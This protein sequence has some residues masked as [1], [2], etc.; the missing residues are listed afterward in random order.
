MTIR[1]LV[2]LAVCV[3]VFFL[4]PSTTTADVICTDGDIAS[5]NAERCASSYRAELLKCLRSGQSI[6][7]CP[8]SKSS[9]YCNALSDSCDIRTAL[10]EVA[11][12]INP[13]AVSSNDCV[14][15][16]TSQA[17]KLS[18][19]RLKRERR[20]QFSKVF[21]DLVAAVE[22]SSRACGSMPT[23]ASSC[24][25]MPTVEDGTACVLSAALG[26]SGVV[27]TF[28]P[29]VIDSIL[30]FA[31]S[32][33]Y[34]TGSDFFSCQ[35]VKRDADAFVISHL[36]RPDTPHPFDTALLIYSEKNNAAFVIES[37]PD[38]TTTIF[39]EVGGVRY[40]PAT[41]TQYF[42]GAGALIEG[43]KAAATALPKT[44]STTTASLHCN[45]AW[46][47][48]QCQVPLFDLMGCLG[49]SL[50]GDL[51]EFAN[52]VRTLDREQGLWLLIK[53]LGISRANK[54][55]VK[56]GTVVSCLDL[57]NSSTKDCSAYAF[58][59]GTSCT[60]P[61][62]VAD[63]ACPPGGHCAACVTGYSCRDGDC[64]ITAYSPAGTLCRERGCAGG[65]GV[66][67]GEC[68]NSGDPLAHD[69]LAP[70]CIPKG[71]P[72]LLP[73]VC[74]EESGEAICAACGNDRLDFGEVCDGDH[75]SPLRTC[76][77][78]GYVSGFLS[79]SPSCGLE[80]D[81]CLP[82]IA[83]EFH[84]FTCG[85]GSTVCTMHDGERVAVSALATDVNGDIVEVICDSYSPEGVPVADCGDGT[86]APTPMYSV[87]AFFNPLE[88]GDRTTDFSI[89]VSIRVIDQAGLIGH[90]P[91]TITLLAR[92]SS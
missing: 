40:N 64:V 63:P 57:L 77:S 43:I 29:A 60:P 85:D 56:V 5:K 6:A 45:D 44:T 75:F 67:W 38:G 20:R 37:N 15:T 79:C 91:N 2:C 53:Q 61:D 76:Q 92:C 41:G 8:T 24:A 9:R 47:I 89:V 69:I 7:G 90:A 39:D 62:W 31:T 35:S 12:S 4:I 55:K 25:S 46:W 13:E 80:T 83:P 17:L 3:A 81:T 49:L 18:V 66:S 74:T 42:N 82:A 14:L 34:Q 33:G 30:A 10:N 50:P 87:D 11:F 59:N 1:E 26:C 58:E 28:P 52:W 23:M 32:I 21:S 51:I 68:P 72:C 88:C 78:E 71:E 73:E 54:S 84:S 86:F 22:K 65:Q 48:A 70:Y 19:R 27:A 16:L 36:L